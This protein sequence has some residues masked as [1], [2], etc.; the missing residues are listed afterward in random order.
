MRGLLLFC[1]GFCLAAS[2]F[3]QSRTAPTAT[4]IRVLL[5][6]YKTGHPLKSRY[7]QLTGATT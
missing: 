6:D 5:L 7:V 3:S 2:T 4:E 1:A